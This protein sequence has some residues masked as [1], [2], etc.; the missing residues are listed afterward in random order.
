MVLVGVL[1]NNILQMV[2]GKPKPVPLARIRQQC[3]AAN[4][5][6]VLRSGTLRNNFRAI[7]P[8]SVERRRGFYTRVLGDGSY[9]EPEVLE[10]IERERKRGPND[11]P[12]APKNPFTDPDALDTMMEPMKRSMVMMI[13]QTVIMGWI[14][15]FFSGFVLSACL[16]NPSNCRFR[17]HRRS[18]LCSS[19]TSTRPTLTCRGCRPLAGTSSISTVWTRFTAC[20]LVITIVRL[21]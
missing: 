14:N 19:A 18:R 2:E 8:S 10:A 20:C 1:R 15:F 21:R 7:P 6:V 13:P 3:V 16:A 17:L 11:L 5:N 4:R 12:D 9:L